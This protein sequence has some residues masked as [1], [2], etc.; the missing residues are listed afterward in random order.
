MDEPTT[1]VPVLVPWSTPLHSATVVQIARK[2][3]DRVRWKFWR[4][5]HRNKPPHVAVVAAARELAGFVWAMAQQF[6][7][8]AAV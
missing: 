4:V 1:W 5:L 7:A 6:P 3:Q 2:A 8:A